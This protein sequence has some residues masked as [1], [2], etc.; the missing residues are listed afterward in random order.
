MTKGFDNEQV[1]IGIS[2]RPFAKSFSSHVQQLGRVMRPYPG[3]EFA[4]WLDHSGNYLNFL[5]QWEELYN[6]GVKE[7]SDDSEKPFKQ[8]T[9]KEKDASKC[10][11]CGAVWKGRT[12]ICWHCGHVR[13]KRN[14]VVSL[15]GEM[16]ELTSRKETK[17]DKYSTEYKQS[18]YRQLLGYARSK[19]YQDG[20]AY[21]KYM[22]KFNVQPAWKKEAEAPGIDVLNF[23]KYQAIKY[24]KRKAVA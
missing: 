12:D 2:A 19:G 24:S 23:V 11:Q 9:K 15:P 8:L 20:W 17:Q 18:F 1:M 5:N 6:D 21:H 7:L 14:E 22:A 16:T 4:L 13:V 10:S 3:K